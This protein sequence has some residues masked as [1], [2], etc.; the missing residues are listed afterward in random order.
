MS[1]SEYPFDVASL[2]DDPSLTRHPPRMS[3]PAVAGRD[4]NPAQ[5]STVSRVERASVLS[6]FEYEPG[7]LGA[8][9]APANDQPKPP[10]KLKRKACRKQVKRAL[11]SLS[12]PRGVRL[13]LSGDDITRAWLVAK[14]GECGRCPKM[15]PRP[16][17]TPRIV[18]SN[19]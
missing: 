5:N 17:I 8:A 2:W 7:F 18:R 13:M 3:R 14:C 1:L 11:E 9:Y 12:E 15:A 10:V 6:E 19:D 4:V 16:A